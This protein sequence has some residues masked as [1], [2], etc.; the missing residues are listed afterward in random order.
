MLEEDAS[1]DLARLL[2]L[3][4][5]LD[6]GLVGTCSRG[7]AFRAC[8]RGLTYLCGYRIH[9]E[10]HFRLHLRLGKRDDCES[11]GFGGLRWWRVRRRRRNR[12]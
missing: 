6:R 10:L 9:H 5:R 12:C 11:G 2:G 7:V 3:G 4:R 1:V 8:S